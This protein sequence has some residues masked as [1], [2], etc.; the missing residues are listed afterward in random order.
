MLPNLTMLETLSPLI[1]HSLLMS[2]FLLV[3]NDKL[4]RY[5][6]QQLYIYIKLVSRCET[7]ILIRKSIYRKLVNIFLY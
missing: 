6:L 7:V 3:T 1:C 5:L 2:S 4:L